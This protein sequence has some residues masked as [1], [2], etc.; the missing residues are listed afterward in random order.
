MRNSLSW[1][2]F[3]LLL[4]WM[5]ANAQRT[6]TLRL[7]DWADVDEIPLD[8]KVIAAFMD[9]YPNIEILYEPKDRKSVV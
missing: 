8:K 5:P 2:L 9:R 7:S 6:V 1:L 3:L 4:M